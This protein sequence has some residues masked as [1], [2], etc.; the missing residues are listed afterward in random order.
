[1]WAVNDLALYVYAGCGYCED[2]RAALRDLGVEV[3][4]RDIRREPEHR[5]ALLSARG[6]GTVPVLRIAEDTWIPESRDI[7]RYLYERFGEEGEKPPFSYGP[8]VKVLMWGLLL[9]GGVVAEPAQ[10][11]LWSLA[12]A[13]AAARSFVLAVRTKVWHHWPIGSVFAFGA[14]SISLSAAE[15]VDLPWWYAAFAV[16]A[17]VLVIAGLRTL[18]KT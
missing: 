18:R 2:V 10:S 15:V 16:A 9:G 7:I 3:E 6:R 4:E 11:V 1:M 13:V 12:C 5:R 14:L 17:V 8:Y